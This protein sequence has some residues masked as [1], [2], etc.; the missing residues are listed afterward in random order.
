ME[1]HGWTLLSNTVG[2]TEKHRVDGQQRDEEGE[3]FQQYTIQ[4]DSE[5]D[6]IRYLTAQDAAD[7]Q[8]KVFANLGGLYDWHN[9]PTGYQV[10]RTWLRSSEKHTDD[11]ADL[12]LCGQWRHL[13]HKRRTGAD[14]RPRRTIGHLRH[15]YEKAQRASGN[16]NSLNIRNRLIAMI[17]GAESYEGLRT[18]IAPKVR[19]EIVQAGDTL[20]VEDRDPIAQAANAKAKNFGEKSNIDAW[21]ERLI[22]AKANAVE[23]VDHALGKKLYAQYAYRESDERYID[24][25]AGEDISRKTFINRL[26]DQMPLKRSWG[27][28]NGL[29]HRADEVL[30]G[31]LF[32][33]KKM[34]HVK[35]TF[36]EIGGEPIRRTAAG[37]EANQYKPGSFPVVDRPFDQ[38]D[39]ADAEMAD[40]IQR[41]LRL[42]SDDDSATKKELLQNLAHHRQ[43]PNKRIYKAHALLSETQGN[44]QKRL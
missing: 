16:P 10:A 32:G 42:I 21:R 15:E 20:T 13:E 43:H 22:P 26:A 11:E 2:Q 4:T 14:N 18:D 3:W 30:A 6:V 23:V 25:F 39:P 38:N 31:G 9:S 44:R 36:Y 28:P 41:H 37:W 33:F 1:R 12:Y 17:N 7:E 29:R 24:L 8:T 35:G 27:Q 5:E 40:M 34:R 19:D